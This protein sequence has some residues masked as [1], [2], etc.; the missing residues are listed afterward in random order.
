MRRL[1]LFC[2]V[3]VALPAFAQ[4]GPGPQAQPGLGAQPGAAPAAGAQ[5]ARPPQSVNV[6]NNEQ[7]GVLIDR[8]LGNPL[9]SPPHLSHGGFI[10]HAILT[11][12]NP[13]EPGPPAA[14]LEYRKE[15]STAT[16]LAGETT[17]LVKV[18]DAFVFYVKS[19]EGR[20]DD[21]RQAWDLHG[22]MAI[23]IAPNAPHRFLNTSDKPL[24]LIMVTWTE[25]AAF[26]QPILVRDIGLLPWCEENAHW[27]NFSKCVFDS[28]DGMAGTDH[29]LM[30]MLPPFE[31]SQ[32][33]THPPG[34]EE[35]WTKVSPGTGLV[36][37]GSQLRD[38]PENAAYR[39]PPNSITE[40]SN[41]NTSKDQPEWYFYVSR[42]RLT[43]GNPV[44]GIGTPGGIAADKTPPAGP[45]PSAV[46]PTPVRPNPN[47]VPIGSSPEKVQVADVHS[48]PL[49]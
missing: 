33:H 31:A 36:L 20:L 27:N 11:A 35:V 14:V 4:Q 24:E 2:A 5:A 13:Y 49:K 34:H 8:F 22:N 45:L 19:G 43:T 23:L 41:I 28:N 25:T 15:L 7:S 29:I 44:T 30:V 1:L 40:H 3:I 32:P 6:R 37:I 26:K 46:I 39:V 47:I 18:P 48:K 38:F 17:Q 16:L 9:N 10:T 12:G 21:G 42:T